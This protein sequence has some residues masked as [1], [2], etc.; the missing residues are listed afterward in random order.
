MEQSFSL[1]LNLAPVVKVKAYSIQSILLNTSL[2]YSK[3]AFSTY[4][5]PKYFKFP[6][7]NNWSTKDIEE[8]YSRVLSSDQN[9][10]D[11]ANSAEIRIAYFSD[12]LASFIRDVNEISYFGEETFHAIRPVYSNIK[13]GV[14]VF[15]LYNERSGIIGIEAK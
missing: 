1:H 6:D 9:N 13:G 15:G 11:L 4:L 8:R 14:G 3:P 5:Q 2:L 12:E 10:T 7:N